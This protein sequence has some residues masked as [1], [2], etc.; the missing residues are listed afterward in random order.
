MEIDLKKEAERLSR[1]PEEDVR[2]EA[3]L[4]SL[5]IAYL[6][7]MGGKIRRWCR[8]CEANIDR[9]HVNAKF[10]NSH[11]KDSYWNKRRKE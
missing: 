8:N 11:C 7:K 9:K 2:T 3:I 10:C 4:Y 6:G 5:T 1:I